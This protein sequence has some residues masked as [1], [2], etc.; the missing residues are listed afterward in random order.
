[1]KRSILRLNWLFACAIVLIALGSVGPTRGGAAEF[2]YVTVFGAQRDAITPCLTHCFATF[3]CAFGV[4]PCAES[5]RLESF[6]VSWMP[7]SLEL[8]PWQLLPETGVNL[9]LYQTLKWTAYHGMRV[10]AWGPFQIDKE[11]Y[12]RACRQ[13][14]MLQSGEVEYKMIDT[15]FCSCRVA[16]CSHAVGNIAGGPRRYVITPSYGETAGYYLAQRFSPWFVNACQVH[17][18]VYAGMGLSAA[19]IVRRGLD[20]PPRSGPVWGLVKNALGRPDAHAIPSLI[21]W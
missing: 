2:Y 10:S 14:A 6:T 21:N 1:M 5:Y 8:K 4:G 13:L 17:D 7:R 20:E 3:S 11:L 19:P 18:W 15:G 16:N 9:D 12:D